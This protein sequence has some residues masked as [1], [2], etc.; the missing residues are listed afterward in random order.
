MGTVSEQLRAY[1]GYD[2]P[3]P[4]LGLE[5]AKTNPGKNDPV[6]VDRVDA[7]HPGQRID[8][9][10]EKGKVKATKTTTAKRAPAKKT[11]KKSAAKKK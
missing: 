6:D 11:A 1:A 9:A 10:P 3:D 5:N 2:S 8:E 4:S 7:L